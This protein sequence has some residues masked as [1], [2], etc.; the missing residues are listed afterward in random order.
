MHRLT[1]NCIENDNYFYFLLIASFLS[2]MGHFN[3][4][5]DSSLRRLYIGLGTA[6]LRNGYSGVRCTATS[7]ATVQFYYSSKV[8]HT[9]R[10]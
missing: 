6:E 2:D 7:G 9:S 5:Q 3:E 4:Q 1:R 10:Q 8:G